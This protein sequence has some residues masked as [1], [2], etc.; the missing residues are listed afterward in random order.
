M[1]HE[2][3]AGRFMTVL[4]LCGQPF[5][6]TR[7]PAATE[8]RR[9]LQAGLGRYPREQEDISSLGSVDQRIAKANREGSM[10]NDADHRTIGAAARGSADS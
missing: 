2:S 4:R 5:G 8:A 3:G 6:V 9:Q 10:T 7:P 1:I